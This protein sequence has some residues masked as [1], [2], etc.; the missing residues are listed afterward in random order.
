MAHYA[1]A[2]TVISWKG[3]LREDTK[4]IETSKPG[5]LVQAETRI[6]AMRRKLS[7]IDCIVQCK[8]KNQLSQHQREIER[9]LKHWYGNTRVGTLLFR[10][11]ELIHDLKVETEKMRR[12]KTFL[13]RRRINNTFSS[14]PKAI[15]RGFRKTV[16][17]DINNPPKKKKL[18]IFGEVFG[19]KKKT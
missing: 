14:N 15:Y 10:K 12:R 9:K 16:E 5:W 6:A 1:T 17:I 19:I 7:F 4:R 11:S 13:E 8:T 2:I 3:N 18:K